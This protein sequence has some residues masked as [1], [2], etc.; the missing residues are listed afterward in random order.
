MRTGDAWRTRANLLTLLRL[1]AAPAFAHEIAAGRPLAASALFALA[2][3]SDLADG[4]V[5]RR[6]GEASAFGAVADHA[7]DAIFVASGAAALAFTG[8]LPAPLPALIALAFAQY[9]LDSRVLAAS[10][11]A[12]SALGRWNGIAYYVIVAVPVVRDALG[13]AWP[14]AGLVRGLGWALV[15]TTLASML[16]RLRRLAAAR[17]A[18]GSPA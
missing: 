5:A 2:V 4:V 3:A 16:D 7:V 14:P 18:R 10:G 12:A 6:F 1:L 8:V 11:L 17:R 9:A 15:A 13:L